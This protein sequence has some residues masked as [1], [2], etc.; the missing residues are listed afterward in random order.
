MRPDSGE[1]L[2]HVAVPYGSDEGFRNLAVPR[3]RQ[4]LADRRQVLVVARAAL[5]GLL[6]E[7]LGDDHDRVDERDP[8]SW[9]T[10]PQRTL[11]TC[12][13]YAQ[14]RRTLLVGEPLWAGRSEIETREW[15]RYESVIN[16]A[17]AG[18]HAT[19]LC[20]YDVRTAPEIALRHARMT[21][22]LL[23]GETGRLPSPHFVRPDRLVLNGDRAPLPEPAGEV[24]A[25]RFTARSLKELRD[26]VTGYAHSAGMTGDLAASLV[27]SVSEIAANSIEHGAGHGQVRMWTSGTGVVCEISDSGGPL[28]DP[29]PGYIPPEPES[30]RG[31]GLWISR[32]LCDLV[33]LRSQ[34]GMVRVR[35]HMRLH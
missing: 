10:H 24:R 18:V 19:A 12:H 17:L 11:A 31:Y 8:E 32:Q 22:P 4:A 29:L 33:E 2:E 30:L 1:P 9:Y 20:F 25:T 3:I 21:H 16:T 27:L 26:T 35:L 13:D 14:G 6:A 23:Y 15:I 28:E 7:A 5:R 34:D